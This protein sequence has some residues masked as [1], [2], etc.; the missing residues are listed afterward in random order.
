MNGERRLLKAAR[1]KSG[2]IG[3]V[4]LDERRPK[5]GVGAASAQARVPT[6]G[7]ASGGHAVELEHEQRARE[8]VPRVALPAESRV[9][10]IEALFVLKARERDCPGI[11]SAELVCGVKFDETLA[12]FAGVLVAG[13]LEPRA[14]DG[15]QQAQARACEDVVPLG[16][17][18]ERSLVAVRRG[19]VCS[20]RGRGGVAFLLA[21]LRIKFDLVG[22]V[23]ERRKRGVGVLGVK[24]G[25][26][27]ASVEAIAVHG[28]CLRACR[29]KLV[30]P[31]IA[32]G[33][34]PLVV[35]KLLLRLGE[36]VGGKRV[37]KVFEREVPLV[38]EE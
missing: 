38:L 13:G 3:E 36:V 4:S 9:E 11:S 29:T 10:G 23:Q 31:A 8:V 15:A 26:N 5:K 21:G 24:H 2:A 35:E 17:G 16:G 25:G 28:D 30:E 14:S 6:K 12:C 19:A 32:G 20:R 7:A 1:F 33:F 34:V 27:R 18:G 22:E 37:G